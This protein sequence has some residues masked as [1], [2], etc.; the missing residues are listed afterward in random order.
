MQIKDRIFAQ[1]CASPIVM[2]REIENFCACASVSDIVV[3]CACNCCHCPSL[4]GST[5]VDCACVVLTHAQCNPRAQI[6]SLSCT[7]VIRLL[8]A[9]NLPS[10]ATP[11]QLFDSAP[12]H[13]SILPRMPNRTPGA[14]LLRATPT[15][16]VAVSIILQ[17]NSR[18]L[19]LAVPNCFLQAPQPLTADSEPL[20]SPAEQSR[21]FKSTCRIFFTGYATVA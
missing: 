11:P 16:R 1:P 14:L 18:H 15:H 3:G 17:R 19:R 7:F 2:Q 10:F 21:D 5:D 20:K 6:Y 8:P 4:P 12:H 13:I 9:L